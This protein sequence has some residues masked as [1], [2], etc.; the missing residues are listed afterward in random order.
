MF[1][2]QNVGSRKMTTDDVF[3]LFKKTDSNT[4]LA[5]LGVT[6]IGDGGGSY[7]FP[8]E[9]GSQFYWCRFFVNLGPTTFWR[10]W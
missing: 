7:F 10:K 4:I 3:I 6:C 5:C 2:D 9:G 8:K 1:D